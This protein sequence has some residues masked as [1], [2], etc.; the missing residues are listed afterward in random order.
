M[1]VYTTV[2]C[3]LYVLPVN[4]YHSRKLVQSRGERICAGLNGHGRAIADTESATTQPVWQQRAERDPWDDWCGVVVSRATIR[5]RPAAGSAPRTWRPHGRN[6]FFFPTPGRWDRSL[7]PERSEAN[8]VLGHRSGRCVPFP[9][10]Y[11]LISPG[12][13]KL[14]RLRPPCGTSFFLP[15]CCNHMGYWDFQ[16]CDQNAAGFPPIKDAET[17]GN[18][19]PHKYLLQNEYYIPRKYDKHLQKPAAGT[20]LIHHTRRATHTALPLPRDTD[21]NTS[22]LGGF[23]HR[24]KKRKMM[25]GLDSWHATTPSLRRSLAL[26]VF[27]R[28]KATEGKEG[29]S[30]WPKTKGVRLTKALFS[31]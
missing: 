30:L 6:T 25:F 22:L 2:P 4:T 18:A 11:R 19:L 12:T 31:L 15:P 24:R 1:A 21:Q 29:K 9:I 27:I 16:K 13:K 17:K 10:S 5:L 26:S 28:F 3:A 20:N 14:A 7:V 23:A 8:T